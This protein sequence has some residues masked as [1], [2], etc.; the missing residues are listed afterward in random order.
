[1]K[2]KQLFVPMTLMGA[3]MVGTMPAS[4]AA[5]EFSE[6]LTGTGP[7]EVRTDLVDVGATITTT[8]ET[9]NF[10]L[11]DVSGPKTLLL[12]GR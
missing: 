1:M 12:K 4:A 10:S 6:P 8:A 5:I 9:A 11:G 7:I 2:M 3:C